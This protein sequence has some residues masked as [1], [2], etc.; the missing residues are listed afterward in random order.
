MT[1]T[2]EI[3]LERDGDRKAIRALVASAFPSPDEADLVERLR[4]DGDV[5]YALVACEGDI[6]VSHIL[7]SR[8]TAPFQALGLAPV[9]TAAASRRRGIAAQLIEAGLARARDDGWQ[10]VFVL[11]DP[12]YYGRFGFDA[13]LA[14]GFSSPHAGEHF[15]ALTLGESLPTL[16]GAVAYAPAFAALD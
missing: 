7:F 1:A 6:V 8:M 10:G 2:I 12:A 4:A 5:V 13:A 15:M 14:A 16:T 9:S 3:R 11:G